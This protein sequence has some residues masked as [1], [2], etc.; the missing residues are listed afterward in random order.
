MTTNGTLQAD[1]LSPSPFTYYRGRVGLYALLKALGIGPG[2][3]VAT[4]AFTCVAVPEG[5]M[6]AGARPVFVDLEPGGLNLSPDDLRRKLT[7]RT[8]AI[9]VQHTF[10]IPARIDLVMSISSERSLPVLEDC[11]H[12]HHATFHGQRLGTFGA[13]SF[14]S[15]EW[16]KPVVLGVGG[17]IEVND[18]ELRHRIDEQYRKFSAPPPARAIK[19][20]IQKIVFDALL[21]PRTYWMLKDGFRRLSRAGMVEGNYHPMGEGKISDDFRWRMLPALER[22]YRREFTQRVSAFTSHSRWIS[23]AYSA[24]LHS[25]AAQI[26]LVPAGAEP[27]YARYPLLV[28]DK[29]RLV[30]RAREQGIEV[31]DWYSTPVHPLVESEWPLVHYE[32][33]SCPEA[34]IRV[35]QIVS[36][37][38]YG[39]VTLKHVEKLMTVVNE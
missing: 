13:G 14:C 18:P 39:R 5:I 24:G 6:A 16:G 15:Y 32:A 2:D 25:G 8:K 19:V 26:P 38:T 1:S 17:S 12:T 21:S 35:G 20:A 7:P 36:L 30:S 11:C 33:G 23:A 22:N 27:V 10:G 3:E 29:A 28:A 9:V 34:E 4:Q 31:S 37:P